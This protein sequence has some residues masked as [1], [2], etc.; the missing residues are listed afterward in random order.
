MNIQLFSKKYFQDRPILFLNLLVV[1]GALTNILNT[2]FIDTS[3]T[4]TTL[5]Y[6]VATNEALDRGS[7][8]ELYS[9]ALFA[10]I[11]AMTAILLSARVYWMRRA[12]SIVIL[13]LA[14]VALIFNFIVTIMIFTKQ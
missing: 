9:F 14:I 8:V 10:I 4:V 5:R 13:S 2:L 1:L 6:R 12:I 3:Q 7:P 11:I